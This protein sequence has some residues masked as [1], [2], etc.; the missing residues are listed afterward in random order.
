MEK[1]VRLFAAILLLVAIADFDYGFYMLIRFIIC[2]ISV[3]FTFAAYKT[4]NERWMW[5]YGMLAALFNPF[6]PIHLSKSIWV[7]NDLIVAI[8]F[9][10]SVFKYKD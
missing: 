7:M 8:T 10:I 4:E 2:T 6:L 1:Y 5:I 9:V 3:Y